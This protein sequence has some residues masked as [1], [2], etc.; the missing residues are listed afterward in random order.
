MHSLMFVILEHLSTTGA[1][2]LASSLLSL[3]CSVISVIRDSTV[4]ASQVVMRLPGINAGREPTAAND[5]LRYQHEA[6]HFWQHR[7]LF[8]GRG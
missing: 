4:E 7:V 8:S 3:L 2:A 1:D 6:G 5:Q